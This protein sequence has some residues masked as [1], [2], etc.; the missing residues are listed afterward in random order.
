MS[1]FDRLCQENGILYCAD[2]GTRLGAIRHNGFIPWDDDLDIVVDRKNYDKLM[3]LDLSAYGLKYVRKT[4]IES[5]VFEEETSSGIKPIV[6]IFIIDNTPDNKVLRNIKLARIMMV[7]GLW[8]HYHP[9]EYKGQSFL[10]KAYSLIFGFLGGFYK[11]EEIFRKFQKV[12]MKYN[13]RHTRNVQC[14]NYLTKELKVQYPS[15]ILDNIVRHKFETI[16]INIPEK[17]DIY[18]RNLYGEYMVPAAKK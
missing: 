16:E 14:F 9:Q 12:S 5:L 4:F 10:K 1:V 18:L 7:H 13:R 2:S 11:E 6:D 8:H 17:Y 3:T 15:D